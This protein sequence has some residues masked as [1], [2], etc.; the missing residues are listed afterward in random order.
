MKDRY[1]WNRVAVEGDTARVTLGV[2]RIAPGIIRARVA[3]AGE[4]DT[5][6]K[7]ITTPV[8]VAQGRGWMTWEARLIHD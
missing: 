6:G 3:I 7:H 5:T 8:I 4:F 1:A 2:R